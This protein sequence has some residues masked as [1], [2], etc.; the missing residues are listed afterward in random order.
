MEINA[1]AAQEAK[2]PL[3]PFHYTADDLENYGAEI[4]ISHCGVCHSDLHLVD[5]DWSSGVFPMVPGHEIIG[6]VKS[7]GA[8]ADESLVGQRVGIGWQRGSCLHCEWCI[9]GQENLCP[10]SVATCVRNYGGFAE[11]VV[12]D[13]RFVHPIPETLPSE[14]AAPLLCAGITVYSP[15]DRYATHSKRVGVVGIGGLGHIALQMA[16]K[17]GCDVTAFSTSDSKRDEAQEL[18]AH[19]FINGR[20]ADAMK[21]AR[22][23]F[24]LIISTA[25]VNIDW[26]P[27]IRALRPN[28][29]LCFVGAPSEP[30]SFHAGM[31]FSNQSVA[32]SVIGGR[33]K[34]REMLDFSARH[35]IV[36]WSETL[37]MDGVNTAL[38]RLRKNDVRYRFVLEN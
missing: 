27:Y 17:M 26:T 9:S 3:E 25:P 12:L 28:G 11:T 33:Q 6:T 16:N 18:G 38:D 4:A 7:V 14:T 36:A 15:L 13:S 5:A 10:Q 19:H 29:T 37:P 8:L 30:I 21:A 20:D 31:L 35:G 1:Y 34:M 2:A 22:R 24:D 32:G 23:S